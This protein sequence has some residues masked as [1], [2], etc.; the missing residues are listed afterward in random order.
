[1][2]PYEV[3]FH[4]YADSQDQVNELQSALYDFVSDLYEDGTL[5]RADKVAA[6]VTKAK[7]NPFITSYL[8]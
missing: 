6:L 3:R 8:K 2:K 1:M 4:L 7:T 5:V